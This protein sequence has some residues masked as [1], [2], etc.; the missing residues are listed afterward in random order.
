M[1]KLQEAMPAIENTADAVS[2][3]VQ[4]VADATRLAEQVKYYKDMA[5]LFG[6]LSIVLL[7]VVIVLGYKCYELNKKVHKKQ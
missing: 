5:T 2:N 4:N 6:I 3:A 7:F 1:D